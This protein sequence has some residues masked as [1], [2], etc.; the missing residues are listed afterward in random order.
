MTATESRSARLLERLNR[1]ADGAGLAAF[2]I[3]FGALM[4]FAV[5]R[6]VARGWVKELY[7]D[8]AFH[9][10]YFGFEWVRPWPAWGMALHFGLMGLGAVGVLLG[11]WTRLSAAVFFVT[12]TYAELIDKTT[13]LNHYYL[14]SLLALLLVFVPAGAM[15]SIDAARGRSALV[16]RSWAYALFRVQV[17][18]VYVFAGL[19]KLNADWLIGAEPL[20]IWLQ[21]HADVPVVGRLLADP[22]TAHL[23][24]YAG[25]AFDL[26]IV[27]LLLW[28]KTRR[29][30]YAVAVLFHVS[31][32][33]L[34]PVGVF[35]WVMLVSATVFFDP[36]WPRRWLGTKLAAAPSARASYLLSSRAAAVA[37]AYV[38]IQVLVPLRFLAYPGNVNWTEEA[39]RFAWRVMLIE[40]SG[41]VEYR[42]HGERGET[43]VQ[44]RRELTP[45]QYKMMSTDPDMIHE[46]ALHIAARRRAAGENRVRV[47]ADA[48]ATL[49]GRPGQRLIDPEVDLAAIPRSLAPQS[50]IVPLAPESGRLEQASAASF[51]FW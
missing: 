39:F 25:A 36:G 3:A 10:T 46:Y 24:S 43:R 32:W 16:V 44:P 5:A 33:L 50:F 11:A 49:N 20:T 27:P 19:A 4:V 40:K 42:V 2:R 6:F 23:M 14:V 38:A 35:S 29:G 12:F 51:G 34:F 18:V 13:Y 48:Y 47:F 30:A 28:E 17:G 31:I 41:S 21:V 37:A 7:L 26:S 22:L 1:P 15:A 8:P 9:F 45:L